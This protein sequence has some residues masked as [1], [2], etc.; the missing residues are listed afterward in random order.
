MN[1]GQKP[2]DTIIGT[3]MFIDSHTHLFYP[4][5]DE[6]RNE[7]IQRA[8]DAGVTQ[9]VV[10]A[11]NLETSLRALELAETY[12][13]IFVALG[14]HPLDLEQYSGE[15]YEKLKE[16]YSHKKVVAVGEIGLDYFYDSSPRDVQ[17][18]I[19]QQQIEWAVE[20]NLPIIVHTR[21]SVQ[22]AID[23]A[24]QFSKENR[25]WCSEK[26][27]GVFHCFS[28]NTEQAFQLLDSGFLVSYPGIVTFK[29]ATVLDTLREVGCKNIMLETD[30]PYLTPVPYRGKRNEPSYIPL[31]AQKIAEVC[32]VSVE[33][34]AKHT[35]HNAQK[36]FSLPL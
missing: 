14:Y 15:Q 35:T 16:L 27:K 19:Y 23:I 21:D 30:A 11:T 3:H 10:P 28:G 26:Y 36:I 4:D 33:E 9:F 17:I 6:D 12:P 2:Q 32:Q 5:F 29:K 22:Q 8:H 24:I 7:V 31:I 18:K 1:F 25:Q 20:K 34:V 13:D